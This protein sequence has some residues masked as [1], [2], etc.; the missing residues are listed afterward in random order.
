MG[1][2]L[3]AC[4]LIP[5]SL[6][7][8]GQDAK[9]MV[10][11]P[12]FNHME[13]IMSAPFLASHWRS[14]VEALVASAKKTPLVVADGWQIICQTDSAAYDTTDEDEAVIWLGR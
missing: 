6:T 12:I 1:N 8:V 10:V 7:D 13:F 2:F 11:P 3:L 9:S 4:A 5:A 14:I